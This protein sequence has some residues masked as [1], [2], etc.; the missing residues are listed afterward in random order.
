MVDES[1]LLRITGLKARVLRTLVGIPLLLLGGV[2]VSAGLGN[3]T[4][5][6]NVVLMGVGAVLGFVGGYTFLGAIRD[7]D[8]AVGLGSGKWSQE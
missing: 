8:V 7:D 3:P 2:M 1:T 4:G 5:L 6:V